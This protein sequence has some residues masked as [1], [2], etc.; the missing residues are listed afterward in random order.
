MSLNIESIDRV[1]PPRGWLRR[2]LWEIWHRYIAKD[3]IDP[4][5]IGGHWTITM[6]VDM[7]FGEFLEAYAELQE[8]DD[9]D[10]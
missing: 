2:W 10:E 1:L 3:F 6:M 4:K 5:S 7:N 9:A 8:E